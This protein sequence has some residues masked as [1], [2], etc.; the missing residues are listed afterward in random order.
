MC[1]TCCHSSKCLLIKCMNVVFCFESILCHLPQAACHQH[2][3]ENILLQHFKLFW[4]G[5]KQNYRRNVL[6]L[7]AA[8]PLGCFFSGLKLQYQRTAYSQHY[9]M[10][11]SHTQSQKYIMYPYTHSTNNVIFNAVFKLN[12][13]QIIKE[14]NQ[15]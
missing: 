9:K 10:C 14:V 12:G 15:Y 1:G 3:A 13:S 5:K 11:I 7:Q 2:R 8:V 4:T 6:I